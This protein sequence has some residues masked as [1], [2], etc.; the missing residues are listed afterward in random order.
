M[1]GVDEARQTQRQVQDWQPCPG[2][3]VPEVRSVLV[4]RLSDP[5][6]T[7]RLLRESRPKGIRRCEEEEPY[8]IEMAA[9]AHRELHRPQQAIRLYRM[10]LEQ[11]SKNAGWRA[12][13]E[14]LEDH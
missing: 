5:A 13:L 7:L 2:A 3:D 10:T 6:L 11:H 12:E 4:A 1:I 14:Q 8:R 9:R